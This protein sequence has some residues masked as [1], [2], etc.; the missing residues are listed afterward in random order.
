MLPERLDG[1]A[2][3]EH[4]VVLERRA[5][6]LQPV[7]VGHGVVVDERHDVPRRQRDTGVAGAGKA[8]RPRVGRDSH[9]RAVH[10]PGV[11][12]QPLEQNVVVIDHDDDLER[13]S[14]LL[15]HRRDGGQQVAPSS[16]GVR[17]DDD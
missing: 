9:I 11:V 15:L 14:R 1:P 12:A 5:E 17:T 2:H 13:W 10:N 8:T 3:A 6:V 16:F 4:P 7:G